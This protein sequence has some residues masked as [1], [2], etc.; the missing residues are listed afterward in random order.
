MLI[1]WN[2][3]RLALGDILGLSR[4]DIDR[5]D[6]V[7]HHLWEHLRNTCRRPTTRRASRASSTSSRRPSTAAPPR[8]SRWPW[9]SG[10]L[11]AGGGLRRDGVAGTMGSVCRQL[12]D[13]SCKTNY[14]LF[15]QKRSP[16]ALMHRNERNCVS[17]RLFSHAFAQQS[18]SWRLRAPLQ[19]P[20]CVLEW[21]FDA[22]WRYFSKLL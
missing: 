5:I 20:W 14:D 4:Y 12:V 16:T 21:V 1:I 9:Q 19:K 13:E 10:T 7:W 6:K 18:V 17:T 15:T 2:C 8:T 11:F 3:F 22:P